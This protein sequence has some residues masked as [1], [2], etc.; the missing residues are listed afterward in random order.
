M[1]AMLSDTPATHA[2]IALLGPRCSG[3]STV[4]ARLAAALGRPFVDLD[5]RV[6]ELG[7]RAGIR[8]DTVGALLERAGAARFRDLESVATRLVLEPEPRI[9]LATGGGVV[10]RADSRA[11]LARAARSVYLVVPLEVLRARLGADPN[12]R[13]A[14][15]GTGAD[16]AAELEAVV[17]RR[18]PLYRSLAEAVV[19]CGEA[20]PDELVARVRAALG[21]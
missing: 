9:V 13:P 3:K 17:R 14:L 10:E 21:V 11:W 4:G 7:R 6:L 8:A 15:T 18:D 2:T 12:P 19:E 5:A 20:P 1:L 16:P